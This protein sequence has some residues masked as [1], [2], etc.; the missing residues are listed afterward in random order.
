[1][2]NSGSIAVHFS[3]IFHSFLVFSIKFMNIQIVFLLTTTIYGKSIMSE[4]H[5]DIK[6]CTLGQL[7]SEIR[8]ILQVYPLDSFRNISLISNVF[9]KIHEYS[10]KFVFISAQKV[11]ILCHS[12]TL[13][14]SFSTLGQLS[15]EI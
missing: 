8:V 11:R 7:S 2:G 5:C 13:I 15:T 10:N 6:F 3:A 12:I 9:I 1:M 4:H 14:S